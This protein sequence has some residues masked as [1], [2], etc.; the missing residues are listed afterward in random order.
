MAF[1]DNQVGKILEVL[2][3][4]PEEVR[5][6]T[7]VILFGD[8]GFHLGD[9]GK[10]TKHTNLEQA[11]RVPLIIAPPRGWFVSGVLV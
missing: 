6:D 4:G 5:D 1:V 3:A 2:D 11:V 7:L 8:H 10:W 9:H